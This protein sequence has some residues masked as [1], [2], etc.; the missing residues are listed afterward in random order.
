[1]IHITIR[2]HLPVVYNLDNVLRQ[3]FCDKFRLHRV[4][5]GASHHWLV[6]VQ[7]IYAT[8]WRNRLHFNDLND[9]RRFP[10]KL[11]D[12]E[13]QLGHEHLLTCEQIS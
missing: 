2:D 12:L 11:I 10:L 5:F 8:L 1:M 13:C 6:K 3:F 4:L 7:E 9:F